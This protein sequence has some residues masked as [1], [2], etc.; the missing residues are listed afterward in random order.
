MF[1][2]ELCKM[3]QNSFSPDY[4]QAKVPIYSQK[5]LH[6]TLSSLY[7]LITSKGKVYFSLP[8]VIKNNFV[9][10]SDLHNEYNALHVV[11]GSLTLILNLI[12][13]TSKTWTRTLDPDSEKPGPWKKW[14]QKNL[15]PEKHRINIELK[16]CLTLT[17]YV[18]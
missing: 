2:C 17:S 7:T 8:Q 4:F 10:A 5:L 6:A 3:F 9:F 14:T 12:L 1:S 15:D 18:L 16:I 13:A 11:S